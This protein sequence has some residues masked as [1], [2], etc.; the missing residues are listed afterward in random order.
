MIG[1]SLVQ[2][3]ALE[4][5]CVEFVVCGVELHVNTTKHSTEEEN[6]DDVNIFNHQTVCW[7]LPCYF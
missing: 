1:F 4:E 2:R 7:R 6:L 5:A 3:G